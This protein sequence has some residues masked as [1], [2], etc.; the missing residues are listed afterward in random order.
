MV[1]AVEILG[2]TCGEVNYKTRIPEHVFGWLARMHLADS[3]GCS[4]GQKGEG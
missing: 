4:P 2:K 3:L 1:E